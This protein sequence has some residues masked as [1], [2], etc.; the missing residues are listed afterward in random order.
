MDT[1]TAQQWLESCRSKNFIDDELLAFIS[2]ED[3]QKKDFAHKVAQLLSLVPDGSIVD[4]EKTMIRGTIKKQGK[5]NDDYSHHLALV[6]VKTESPVCRIDWIS[7]GL[8]Y[9]VQFGSDP[10]QSVL[11]SSPEQLAKVLS[12][13]PPVPSHLMTSQLSSTLLRLRELIDVQKVEEGEMSSHDFFLILDHVKQCAMQ[14][15][16]DALFEWGK[17]VKSCQDKQ[18][19]DIATMRNHR[20]A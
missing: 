16:E 5:S 19:H 8:G 14:M 7:E 17:K 20:K 11:V 6:D 2:G 4:L 12:I 1:Q 13:D 18:K 10:C 15:N 3:D 9:R